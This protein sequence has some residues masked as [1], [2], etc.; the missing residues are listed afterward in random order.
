MRR[1][2]HLD[3][4]QALEAADAVIDVD[5]EIARRERRQLADEVRGLLVAPAAPHHAV[6][7][8]VLL[9][10][11]GEIIGLEAFLEPQHD[12]PRDGLVPGRGTPPSRCADGER[13]HV[14]VLEDRLQALARAFGPGG[15][16]HAPAAAADVVGMGLHGLID[17][18]VLPGSAPPRSSGRACRQ[19]TADGVRALE[20]RKA[21]RVMVSSICVH[22]PAVR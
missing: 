9:G 7:E 17:I 20:G 2:L 8:N 13:C 22:A 15:D 5:D 16:G 19:R 1:A 6:A 14:M 12:E 4:L 11:D 10:D 3:G 18:A 21:S